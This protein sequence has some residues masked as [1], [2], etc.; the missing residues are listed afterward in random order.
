MTPRTNNGLR[1]LFRSIRLAGLNIRSRPGPVPSLGQIIE[2]KCAC[3]A[4]TM[5]VNVGLIAYMYVTTYYVSCTL[6][7]LCWEIYVAIYQ[8][9]TLI[10]IKQ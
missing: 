6:G 8:L 7:I 1:P 3:A 4:Y 10:N 5:G 2:E 9:E